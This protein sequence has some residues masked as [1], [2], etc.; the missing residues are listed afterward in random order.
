MKKLILIV[1]LFSFLISGCENNTRTDETEDSIRKVEVKDS[2]KESKNYDYINK[3]YSTLGDLH[4]FGYDFS[5]EY[6]TLKNQ[7]I[8]LEGF[9]L[10]DIV[11]VKDK[12]QVNVK[13]DGGQ[14]YYVQFDCDT[15]KMLMIKKG[16]NDESKK[17]LVLKIDSVKKIELMPYSKFVRQND[18][19]Y[20]LNFKDFKVYSTFIDFVTFQ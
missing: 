10:I 3:K 2:I 16:Y 8:F 4:S 7:T 5:Y 19:I 17:F 9:E 12:F 15:E 18:A 1:L 6:D 14:A 13:S 11:E 20:L